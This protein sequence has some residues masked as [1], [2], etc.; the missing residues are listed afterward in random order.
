M[1][2]TQPTTNRTVSIAQLRREGFSA[3]QIRQLKA[4][5]ESYPVREHITSSQDMRRLELLRWMHQN[6]RLAD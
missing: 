1:S 5:R 4:L 3:G 2:V 6:G